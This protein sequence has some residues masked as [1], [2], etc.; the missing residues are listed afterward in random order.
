MQVRV[1]EAENMRSALRKVK[2][3]L[4]SDALILSSRSVYK[5]KFGLGNTPWIEVTAAVDGDAGMTG[6]GNG[7]SGISKPGESAGNG[8]EQHPTYT[9]KGYFKELLGN[10]EPVPPESE[11]LREKAFLQELTLMK[12]SFQTLAREFSEV[13]STWKRQWP[14]PMPGYGYPESGMGGSGRRFLAELSELGVGNEVLRQFSEMMAKDP[15]GAMN[16][17][18]DGLLERFIAESVRMKNPFS[19]SGSGQKRL[20]FIGPTG[21]G[22][23]TTIAK[24]AANYILDTGKR[25]ALATID[26]YRIAAVEQLKIYGHI[27]NVPVEVA[28]SPEQ[29]REIFGRHLDKDLILVDTAGRSPKDEVSRRELAAFLDPDLE[30]ENHLVLSTTTG[31]RSLFRIIDQFKHLKTK[32]LVLTKLDESDLFGSILNVHVH[33]GHPLSFFTNGQ[34]VPEDLLLPEPQRLAG[35]ILKRNEVVANGIPSR[36]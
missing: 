5:S 21:V 36:P 10:S 18:L 2:K 22:K 13:K 19:E 6:G 32:G 33:S 28:R 23:T 8:R 16:E 11:S 35:I 30:I 7:P 29:L 20:A 25:V 4:G 1:F 24:I 9:R 26:N 15:E 14:A 17:D 12:Q 31:E 27:M 3:A 34:N